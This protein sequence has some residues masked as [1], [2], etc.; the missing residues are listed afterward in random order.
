MCR[1]AVGEF[2]CDKRS[3]GLARRFCA[4][5]LEAALAPEPGFDQLLDDATIVVSE[6]VTNSVNA[7]CS[8]VRVTLSLHRDRLRMGVFDDAAGHPTLRHPGPQD[9]H[10]RGLAITDSIARGWGVDTVPGGKQVWAELGFHAALA[11]HLDCS[12]TGWS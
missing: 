11:R 5:E 7:G 6:L 3:P 1:D 4:A 9:E 10:G 12:V 8:S 2:A